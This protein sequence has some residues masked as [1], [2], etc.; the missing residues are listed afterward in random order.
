MEVG[1]HWRIE[2][3]N[4]ELD[5]RLPERKRNENSSK[6]WKIRMAVN[7]KWSTTGISFGTNNVF[8]MYM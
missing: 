2:R 7:K 8:S 1:T 6:G 3:I 4:K 5:V